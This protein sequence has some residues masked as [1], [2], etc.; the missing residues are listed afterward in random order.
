MTFTPGVEFLLPAGKGWLLR[1]FA[2]FGGGAEFDGGDRAWIYSAGISA[3]RPLG[4]ERW[5]C[6]LGLGLTWA[7]FRSSG[8]G[9]DSVSSL[10]TGLDFVAPAGPRWAGRAWRPGVFAIY[11]NYLADM[12]FIFDPQGLEPLSEEWELGLSLTAEPGFSIFGYRFERV[13]LSYRRAGD[14][15]GLH[16]ISRFPF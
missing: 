11:R 8:D 6:T 16:I 7:G 5:R 3:T 13:G 4:C 12:G 14:L 9:Q 10:A 2:T 15:R 1:P